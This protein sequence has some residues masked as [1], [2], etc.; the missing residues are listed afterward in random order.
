MT[1]KKNKG[2]GA[3]TIRVAVETK[4][5]EAIRITVP[6]EETVSVPC[7]VPDAPG[8]EV[9]PEMPEVGPEQVFGHDDL[10]F[11]HVPKEDHLRV[12]E[13]LT[14]AL[15]YIGQKEEE[16]ALVWQRK[17]MPGPADIPDEWFRDGKDGPWLTPEYIK[18]RYRISGSA[19]TR[20]GKKRP[21]IRRKRGA[22]YVYRCDVVHLLANRKPDK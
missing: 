3:K 14:R 8:P 4:E 17:D 21:D 11:T 22:S 7:T 16:A 10:M 9:D 19:L 1:R 2:S 18:D 13:M 5:P 15:E 12:I 6:V 20:E